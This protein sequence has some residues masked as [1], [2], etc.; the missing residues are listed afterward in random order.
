MTRHIRKDHLEFL[1]IKIGMK[2]KLRLN[3]RR[4]LVNWKIVVEKLLVNQD[5]EITA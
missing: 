4:D 2:L 5:K 3:P 1:K